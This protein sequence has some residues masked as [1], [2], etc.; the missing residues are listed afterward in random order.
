MNFELDPHADLERL[1]HEELT[2]SEVRV[3]L[4]RLSMKDVGPA[5]PTVGAVA[6]L[7]GVATPVVGRMLAEI[8]QQNLHELYGRTL[9][10]HGEK[11]EHLDKQVGRISRTNQ[12]DNEIRR[13]FEEKKRAGDGGAFLWVS[14]L[15]IVVFLLA[16]MGANRERQY[17]EEHPRWSTTGSKARPFYGVPPRR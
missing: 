7:C 11:I 6:E 13:D 9:E 3:L 4:E 17:I 15:V 12:L 2:N 8:R 5:N 1:A 10:T 16:Q 14:L